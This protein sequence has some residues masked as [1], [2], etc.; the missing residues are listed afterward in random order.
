MLCTWALIIQYLSKIISIIPCLNAL[1]W[2][3]W[4]DDDWFDRILDWSFKKPKRP[5]DLFREYRLEKIPQPPPPKKTILKYAP[6]SNYSLYYTRYR[7]WCTF[8][9]TESCLTLLN[10]ISVP[11]HSWYWVELEFHNNYRSLFTFLFLRKLNLH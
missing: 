1:D 2:N 6:D 5:Y 10:F 4:I 7:Q 3:S 11:T 8:E 9:S